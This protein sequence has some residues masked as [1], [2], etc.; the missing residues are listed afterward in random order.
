MQPLKKSCKE[1]ATRDY[2]DGPS[3]REA[4]SGRTAAGA[5]G[6]KDRRWSAD[7]DGANLSGA[8][9]TKNRRQRDCHGSSDGDHQRMSV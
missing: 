1:L 7:Q 9:L 4:Y 6:K 8:E 2:D 5:T 3:D